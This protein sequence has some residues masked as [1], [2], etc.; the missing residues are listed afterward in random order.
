MSFSGRCLLAV[1]A[2]FSLTVSLSAQS[3][4]KQTSKVAR[5]SVSGRVTIKDKGAAGVAVG[6]RRNDGTSPFEPFLK[7]T[8]DQDGYYRIAN[9]SA[10]N[11][12][13]WPATPGF[14]MNNANNERVRVVVV[15]EDENIE[16]VNF[17]LIRGGVITGKV[18]DADG[19]AVIQQEVRLYRA[20]AFEQRSQPQ[21]PVFAI[22]NGQTDDRGIYRMYGLP[23][24]RYK[25]AVGRGEDMSG[26]SLGPARAN[27][28]QVFHPDVTDQARA[29]VIEV[30]EGSE[31]NNVDITLG[32]AM[33]TFSASGRIVDAEKGL[34]VPNIRFGFQ[35]SMG[36]RTEFTGSLSS[37]NAQGDF[38][39]EG[40][41]PGKYGVYLLA[42]QGGEMRAETISFDVI[43]QDVSGLTVRLT[44][45]A[46][47]TGIVVLEN[48]DK[49]TVAKLSQLQLRAFVMTQAGGGGFGNSSSSPISPDG[50]FRLA[51]LPGGTVN[52]QLSSGM[53]PMPPKGFN[54]SRVE[55]E[56]V[57]S[58][59]RLEI[60][61]GEQVTGVRVI[62]T[63]G[64]A[65]LRGVVKL[66]NGSLPEGARILLRLM[67]AG[68]QM[69]NIRPPQV[70]ARGHFF[71]DGIPPGVYELSAG[72]LGASSMLS[73]FVKQEVTV[74]DGVV[75][76]V[77][78]TIDV[79]TTLKP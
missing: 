68:E 29:T 64:N 30:S 47:L 27:Y 41:I 67:K 20:D 66:E 31:A 13:V 32:R 71:M 18:T 72:I 75:T 63:Y 59:S 65:S 50:S 77:T 15:G 3:T 17:S 37:S 78:I 23:A 9:V 43:D 28:K 38:V 1:F 16:D 60:K 7:T 62:V 70:D 6:L 51:G 39:V 12:E 42:N 53:S 10:G 24:G 52:L 4:T 11:Y 14:V 46:S 61:E 25:V 33:Q 69:S 8:T 44:K 48:E 55:R 74:Q 36:Q 5:S 58:T 34:P 54:I 76:D 49:A 73:R 21:R 19:R 22:G 26:P 35:R 45:G 56:G 40:L 79:G 57:G 2:F